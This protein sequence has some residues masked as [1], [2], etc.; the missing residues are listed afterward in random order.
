MINALEARRMTEYAKTKKAQREPKIIRFYVGAFL[1]VANRY[2]KRN[3]KMG[4]DWTRFKMSYDKLGFF[5]DIIDNFIP[6]LERDVR[7]KVME[8]VVQKLIAQGFKVSRDCW[9]DEFRIEWGE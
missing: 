3:A 1:R 7:K 2:I 5:D 8:E 6:G 4:E 9:D